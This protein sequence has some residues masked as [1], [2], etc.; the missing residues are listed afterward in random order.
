M[1]SGE[2]FERRLRRISQLRDLALGLRRSAR[3]AFLRGEIPYEPEYDCR[4]DA[5]YWR[6]MAESARLHVKGGGLR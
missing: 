3:A 4:S 1:I 5:E 2:E 6:R